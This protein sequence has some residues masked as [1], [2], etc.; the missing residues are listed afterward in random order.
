MHMLFF[1]VSTNYK[2]LPHGHRQEPAAPA[3]S[4]HLRRRQWAQLHIWHTYNIYLYHSNNYLHSMAE[5][6]WQYHEI[7]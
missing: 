7:S 1:E 2:S 4:E 5:P 3:E 6:G